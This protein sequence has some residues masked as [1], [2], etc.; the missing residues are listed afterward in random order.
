MNKNEMWNST[1]EQ[2]ESLSLLALLLID[3][4]DAAVDSA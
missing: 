2:L 1:V 3:S 4:A